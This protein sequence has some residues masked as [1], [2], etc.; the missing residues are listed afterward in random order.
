MCVGRGGL[1]VG[2][3]VKPPSA[4]NN[5]GHDVV[6]RR[7]AGRPLRQSFSGQTIAV[8]RGNKSVYGLQVA[9]GTGHFS[10]ARIAD[11]N[12]PGSINAIA[13]IRPFPSAATAVRRVR[14][15]A[16]VLD[17][18]LNES[19]LSSNEATGKLSPNVRNPAV[20]RQRGN[21]DLRTHA[22]RDQSCSSPTKLVLHNRRERHDNQV[23]I[24]CDALVSI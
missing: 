6:G 12:G 13:A 18:Y 17:P 1:P 15:L 14:V 7:S 23:P 3:L 4:E 22:W 9:S 16:A 20:R 10:R 21:L 11:A 19:E 2:L 24:R 8:Q 5:R